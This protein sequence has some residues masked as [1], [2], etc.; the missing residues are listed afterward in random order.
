V[1]ETGNLTV[2]GTNSELL[3]NEEVRAAYLGGHAA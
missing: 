3:G 2:E 1:L